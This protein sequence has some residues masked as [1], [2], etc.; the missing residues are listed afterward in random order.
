MRTSVP[1]ACLQVQSGLSAELQQSLDA[2]EA[3]VRA[4]SA[5]PDAP[6]VLYVSKMV[7][8]PANALPRWDAPL[9]LGIRRS[10]RQITWCRGGDGL[11][12]I[13][14]QGTRPVPF[15]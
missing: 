10:Y 5:G 7:A 9:A 15:C 1:A 14:S 4:C 3:A 11:R 12:A 2:C 13:G 6:L 8:V